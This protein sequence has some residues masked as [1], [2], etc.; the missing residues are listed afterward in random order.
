MD[1]A[2]GNAA[3]LVRRVLSV[4]PVA[5]VM[6]LSAYLEEELFGKRLSLPGHALVRKP[7]STG[8]FLARLERLLSDPPGSR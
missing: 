7:F 3:D 2:G 8:D 1:M 4:S 5:R 6:L